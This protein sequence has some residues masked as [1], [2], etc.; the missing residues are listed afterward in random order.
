MT[1][2]AIFKIINQFFRTI[3]LSLSSTD[4]YRDLYFKYNGYGLKYITMVIGV[5]SIIYAILFMNNIITIK[6]YLE[7]AGGEEMNPVEFILKDWPDLHYDG[8]NIS[9]EDD[10]TPVYISAKDGTKLAVIDSDGKLNKS[11][12]QKVPVVFAKEKI[13]IHLSSDK[14]DSKDDSSN[15]VVTYD[16]L[17][18]TEATIINSEFI[19]T[20]LLDKLKNIG[21]LVFFLAL[22]IIIIVRVGMHI[23]RNLFGIVVL[24]VI[25]WWMRASPTVSSASRVVFFTSGPAEIITPVLLLISPVLLPLA[26]FVEYWAVILAM[27]SIARSNKARR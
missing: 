12:L 13:I 25:L 18:G 17:F 5:T 9:R 14:G 4:F 3:W 24:Y 8:K 19:K 22:P 20:F 23:S 11:E 7:T 27:Y 10:V 16:K 26:M 6:N 21:P 2:F 1:R 15:M